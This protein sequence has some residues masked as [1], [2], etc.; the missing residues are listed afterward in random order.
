LRPTISVRPAIRTPTRTHVCTHPPFDSPRAELVGSV[1]IGGDEEHR[2]EVR[3]DNSC[4]RCG[5]FAKERKSWPRWNGVIHTD[6]VP[7]PWDGSDRAAREWYPKVKAAEARAD[8]LLE[9]LAAAEER[10]R[11]AETR[12]QAEAEA[13][14]VAEGDYL[15]ARSQITTSERA[16][17]SS[18]AKVLSQLERERALRRTA[19]LRLRTLAP[20]S[21]RST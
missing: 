3:V 20:V 6:V 16:C 4:P 7:S 18:A 15:R 9:R 21:T 8:D 14:A 17:A 19:E 1:A 10:A 12:C 2:R 11:V 5:W 13:R